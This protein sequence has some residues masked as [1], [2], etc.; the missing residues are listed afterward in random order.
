METLVNFSRDKVFEG[1]KQQTQTKHKEKDK[2]LG[3][4]RE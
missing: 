2:A 4:A 1:Q 3:L